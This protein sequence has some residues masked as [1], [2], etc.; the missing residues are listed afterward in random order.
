MK[1]SPNLS[2]ALVLATSQLKK[3]RVVYQQDSDRWRPYLLAEEGIY[4]LNNN[5]IEV[6]QAELKQVKAINSPYGIF[7]LFP[8]SQ[9][10]RWTRIQCQATR[11]K[12]AAQIPIED[13]DQT[14]YSTTPGAIALL[15]LTLDFSEAELKAAYHSLSRNYHPDNLE[16]G[17]NIKFLAVR[18]AYTLLKEE[19]DHRGV[20]QQ[21]ELIL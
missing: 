9:L 14:P 16:S 12:L 10:P 17:N 2:S 6:D 13:P 1:T 21:Q 20:D 19:L 18:A 11:L 8:V 15:N 3:T 4:Y 7:C 5:I